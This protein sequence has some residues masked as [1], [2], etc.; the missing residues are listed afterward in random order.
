M[1]QLIRLLPA[2]GRVLEFG[3][4][5]GR[6]ARFLA[7]HGFDVVAIDMASST[8]ASNRD[9]PVQDY[10]GRHIPLG[11][12]S[13]DAIFSSNVLEHLEDIPT[14]LAE[15]R[16][17]LRPGGVGLHVMPT[18][19][20]RFWTFL[21]AITDAT[22]TAASL[23]LHVAIPPAG[24]TRAQSLNADARR[25]A[26]GLLPSG[27][28]TSPE[29]ISE[30]WTFSARRWRRTFAKHGFEI[31]EDKPLGMLYTGTLVLGDRLPLCI[32]RSVSNFLGSATRY[33]L[34]RP[35]V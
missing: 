31:L 6:Q 25:I 29:G 13:V 22:I 18:T 11:E 19:A 16:R 1:E 23:P 30:L 32:R 27:H 34:V 28:G 9:F 26:R 7:D 5:T 24:L 35:S 15:F 4:G 3:A 14:I 33:Y 10:D 21:T 17:V 12:R 8:Y 20:W 2:G